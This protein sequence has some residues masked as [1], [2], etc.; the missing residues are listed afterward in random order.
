MRGNPD[1]RQGA[2]ALHGFYF[3]YYGLQGVSIPFLPLWFASR[4]LDPAVIGLIVA[5]SFLP[6]I[7]ST[8]VVA[9][10]ADQTGRAHALIAAALAASLALFVCY[11]FSSAPGWLLAITLL[12]NAVFPAV[13][14]LMDRMAIASGR[15]QGSS[16]TVMRACGSLGFAVVTLAGGYLI[17][18]FDA[19]WVMWLSIVLIIACLACVRLLPRAARPAA[20]EAPAPA[21]R[22]PMLE[23]LGDRPL[24]MCIA[25]ASLVQA[26]NGFLYSY[27]TLYWTASGL[28]TA[29][30]SML[31]VVGV[32][33]EVLF[34]FLAPRILAR[35]GAQWLI[36]A[37][38]VMTA[39][40]WA[41]LSATTDP[42][43]IAGL[44]L[45]QCF[46]LAGNNAAIMWYITRHVPA[47]IKTS[48]IALY[49]LLSGGVFMFA[50]I[51]LGGALYR[52]YAPG[53]F[54]VM[55]LCA[56]GAVPLVVY[57]ERVRR[58]SV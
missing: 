21:V 25:A 31:W 18:T 39:I 29:L 5:T 52:S 43:L 15:G 56:I 23:V 48:A 19:D 8:P 37:S 9:H 34:F 42:A 35:T 44:Q 58:K 57:A 47:A 11:P 55:S 51:Q 22:L 27:S 40:R 54:L 46:T 32:A 26:S 50:S 38:A 20:G 13:L 7:L 2:I 10:V 45:L 49:A 3:L 17:K 33:S 6:K 12:L 24:L 36:L 14:P 41:G 30:I 53:G 28:S 16:Y 1:P 4:G